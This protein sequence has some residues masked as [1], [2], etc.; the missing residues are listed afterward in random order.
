MCVPDRGVVQ[1]EA[2]GIVEGQAES[3][4][5]V[6]TALVVEQVRL[7]VLKDGEK[8]TARL[9]GGDTAA[10]AGYALGDRG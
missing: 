4:V 2:D 7:D 5:G 10:R 6:V 8:Y 3:L 1:G 9:I